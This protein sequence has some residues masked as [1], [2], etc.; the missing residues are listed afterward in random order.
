MPEYFP[1]DESSGTKTKCARYLV[2]SPQQKQVGK[3]E[4]FDAVG[5]RAERLDVDLG[6]RLRRATGTGKTDSIT[7]RVC[8]GTLGFQVPSGCLWGSYR[9]AGTRL[10]R[11]AHS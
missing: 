7:A 9:G 5:K 6:A 11:A 1:L 10:P 2:D 8:T 3:V 4:V